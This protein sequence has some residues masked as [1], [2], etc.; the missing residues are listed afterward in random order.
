MTDFVTYKEVK[1]IAMEHIHK[2]NNP[3]S[4]R[5]ILDTLDGDFDYIFE[6]LLHDIPQEDFKPPY[7]PGLPSHT[8]DA[9]I[10]RDDNYLVFEFFDFYKQHFCAFKVLK[11]AGQEFHLGIKLI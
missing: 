2:T 9:K 3:D 5:F 10:L 1:A 8:F 7:I 11:I 4:Y 6:V